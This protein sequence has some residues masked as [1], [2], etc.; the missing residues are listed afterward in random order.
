MIFIYSWTAAIGTIIAGKGFPSIISTVQVLVAAGLLTLA[1]YLY[2]D[3]IDREMDETT[4]NERKKE[5]PIAHGEVSVK[6]S[7]IF[8]LI[9]S[10]LGHYITWNINITTF[11]IGLL[12]WTIYMSYSFPLI[13][14]KK[15]FIVKSLV[16]STGPS[17]AL[18]L[19]ASS[20]LNSLNATVLF[21]S[22]VQ[23]SFLFFVLPALSDSF[24]IDADA[25]FGMKTMAM[26]L[27]WK[28]KANMMMFAPILV[29]IMT[30]IAFSNLGLNVTLP[31]L[32][33]LSSLYLLQKMRKISKNYNEDAA[34]KVRK[35]SYAY[36]T[37][38]PVFMAIGTLNLSFL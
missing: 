20:I 16:S 1:V 31:V 6:N 9:C 18:L 28:Q 37:F 21:A 27:N 13:R 8:I 2:N 7:L 12:Y 25:K 5:R 35:I 38:M 15:V 24:D 11:I 32:I 36:F 19:G 30:L 4:K 34:R 10:A 33:S 23:G 22:I 26:V 29:M 14:L 3:V 17:F